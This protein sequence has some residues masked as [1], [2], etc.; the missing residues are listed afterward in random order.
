MARENGVHKIE[1][2]VAGLCFEKRE[3]AWHCLIGRRTGSRQLYPGLWECGGGQLHEGET[4]P[5]ALTRQM[6]EEFGVQIKNILPL[7]TYA[8]EAEGKIIPGVV[9]LC[10]RAD[11]GEVTIDRAEFSDFAW[12]TAMD[13]SKYDLIPGVK[14]DLQA[15]FAEMEKREV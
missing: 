6:R 10:R 9:C 4:F 7:K 15:V 1:V 2:H 11:E 13:L 12:I 3:G 8:I 5:G 14:E